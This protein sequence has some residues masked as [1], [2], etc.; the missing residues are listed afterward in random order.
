M[1]PSSDGLDPLSDEETG[2]IDT[3]SHKSSTRSFYALP[4]E[5]QPIVRAGSDFIY[6]YIHFENPLPDPLTIIDVIADAWE[7]GCQLTGNFMLQA[8]LQSQAYVRR[9]PS[10][11]RR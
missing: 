7:H 9:L 5:A 1:Y 2:Q 6:N 8:D 4:T 10:F 11:L 3:G